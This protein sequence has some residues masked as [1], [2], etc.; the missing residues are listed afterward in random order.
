MSSR[1]ESVRSDAKT[2]AGPLDRA[3]KGQLATRAAML[4]SGRG[5]FSSL[6]ELRDADDIGEFTPIEDRTI[7]TRL[8]DVRG[9]PALK[10]AATA[11]VE[12]EKFEE[13]A[14]RA[15]V[16]DAAA[17]DVRVEMD[18][19]DDK[20]WAAIAKRT[21]ANKAHRKT[22]FF[23]YCLAKFSDDFSAGK[24][25]T[26]PSIVREAIILPGEDMKW[27]EKTIRAAREE[28]ASK[29]LSL[30]MK[31]ADIPAPA[32]RGRPRDYPEDGMTTL[33]TF[34][35]LLRLNNLPVFREIIIYYAQE[36]ILGTVYETNFRD[37]TG[38]WCWSKWQ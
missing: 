11:L 32:S 17:D 12:K 27:C 25:R 13:E 16:A 21:D 3:R 6:K 24:T 30:S 15:A 31:V 5:K 20:P 35:S 26:V 28:H 4:I 36:Q 14:L 29:K 10:A 19:A 23:K 2:P 37:T 33:R 7:Y 34:I 18:E 9:T 8:A 22:M 38:G 1:R